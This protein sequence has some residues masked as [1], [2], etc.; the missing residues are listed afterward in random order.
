MGGWRGG[1]GWRLGGVGGEKSVLR[2]RGRIERRV[3]QARLHQEGMMIGFSF[4]GLS[5]AFGC[6]S[7]D[8][9]AVEIT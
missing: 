9:A 6:F 8:D 2:A 5:E 1:G 7:S 3:R 4:S